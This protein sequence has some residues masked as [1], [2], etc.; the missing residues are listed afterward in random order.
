MTLQGSVVVDIVANS[1][2]PWR[3]YTSS[4][5]RC[6]ELPWW[7][8]SCKSLTFSSWPKETK[9][10]WRLKASIINLDRWG[11][12][13]LQISNNQKGWHKS[14]TKFPPN[15]QRQT[16]NCSVCVSLMGPW[17]R[18]RSSS[19]WWRSLACEDDDDDRWWRN[20]FHCII[21][22]ENKIKK[23]MGF[24]LLWLHELRMELVDVWLAEREIFVNTIHVKLLRYGNCLK[25]DVG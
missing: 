21:I 18:R 14:P 3:G 9:E 6:I 13:K 22:L 17:K 8:A 4:F 1:C 7:E 19:W 11:F 25:D 16:L 23:Q 24:F 15:K 20:L 5:Y 2:H 10:E 12:T